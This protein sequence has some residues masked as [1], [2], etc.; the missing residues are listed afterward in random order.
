MENAIN[1]PPNQHPQDHYNCSS[2]PIPSLFLTSSF[3]S[4]SN[5]AC[6]Q[7]LAAGHCNSKAKEISPSGSSLLDALIAKSM[8]RDWQGGNSSSKKRSPLPTISAFLP[9]QR[10][11]CEKETCFILQRK[12]RHWQNKNVTLFCG[13]CRFQRTF[14][15]FFVDLVIDSGRKRDYK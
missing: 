10:K 4:L 1:S 3:R 12:K 15:N 11:K 9:S 7:R 5:F 14:L 13:F 2:I 6:E 8:A